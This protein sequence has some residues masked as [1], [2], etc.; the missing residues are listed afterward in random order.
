MKTMGGMLLK[1]MKALEMRAGAFGYLGLGT[2][3]A[4][5]QRA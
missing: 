5:V 2:K 3:L 1:S 4:Q